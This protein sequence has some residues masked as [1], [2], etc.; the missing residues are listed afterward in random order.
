[1]M[2]EVRKLEGMINWKELGINGMILLKWI[3]KKQKGDV[4]WN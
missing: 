1:M 4:D 2:V 3:L